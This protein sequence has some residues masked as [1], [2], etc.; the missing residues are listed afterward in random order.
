M[1]GKHLTGMVFFLVVTLGWALLFNPR[2]HPSDGVLIDYL[3]EH[4]VDFDRLVN[5]AQDDY[6]AFLKVDG[7][8]Q[9]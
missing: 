9:S 6:S 2:L 4:R 8:I 3:K 7:L 5:M 1:R